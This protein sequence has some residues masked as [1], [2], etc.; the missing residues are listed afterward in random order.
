MK[1][2]SQPP[3][4]N[5]WFIGVIFIILLGITTLIFNGLLDDIN[6]PN[7]QLTVS[8][9][10]DVVL[11][12]NRY[13]HYVATGTI[14]GQTVTFLLDTGATLVSVPEHIAQQLQLQ[15]GAS[16]LSE[17]ANGM[18]QSYST[19]L[20]SVTLGGIVINNVKGSISSGMAFD[21][22]LLGMS[23]L[24]H[25]NLNQQGKVLVLSVPE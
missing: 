19:N 25:L 21:E 9:N 17:T 23:F 7:Q 15:K 10:Q 3:Q 1:P 20:A 8:G 2:R 22:I 6:N 14:N 5:Q 13:G 4:L 24:K 18:S 16:Y 12:Q 11:K